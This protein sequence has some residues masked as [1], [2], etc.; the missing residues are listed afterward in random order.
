MGSLL[1]ELLVWVG[2]RNF[3]D[4][5]SKALDQR[6]VIL[7]HLIDRELWESS[8]LMLT[9]W[10]GGSR[11]YIT[12]RRYCSQQRGCIAIPSIPSLPNGAFRGGFSFLEIFSCQRQ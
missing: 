8:G 6:P 10:M 11:R 9:S 1:P 4:G 3:D 7:Y 12:Y 2:L 5:K